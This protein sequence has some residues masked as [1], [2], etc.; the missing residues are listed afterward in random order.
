MAQT[1]LDRAQAKMRDRG[2]APG[3]IDSFAHYFELARS[4]ATGIIAE[5]SIAPL[6]APES[7]A[8][9]Q[10][11]P[12]A[13]REALAQ[14]VMIKLNGGLGTSM[15]VSYTHLDV[16]KR[17]GGDVKRGRSCRRQDEGVEPSSRRVSRKEPASCPTLMP[18]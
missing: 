13:A 2:V 17:Q 18:R 4:G 12:D 7:L 8:G 15:A 5:A 1:A 14:T 6:T 9:V 11:D 16:Y 3:A 10:I